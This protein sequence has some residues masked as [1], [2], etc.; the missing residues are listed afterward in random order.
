MIDLLT[1]TAWTF[2]DALG[3]HPVTMDVPE[4]LRASG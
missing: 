3:A 1:Q 2:S 4:E